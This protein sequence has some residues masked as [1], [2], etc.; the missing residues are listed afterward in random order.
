M[1]AKTFGYDALDRVTNYSGATTQTYAYDADGNRTA[2]TRAAS[3]V[4]LTYTYGAANNRLTRH[5]RQRD[6]EFHL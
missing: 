3:S 4:A 5:R 6:R 1:P 2:F